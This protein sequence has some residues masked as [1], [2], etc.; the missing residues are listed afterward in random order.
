MV[1]LL[2]TLQWRPSLSA[3][4]VPNTGAEPNDGVD[5]PND[6]VDPKDGALPKEGRPPNP[7]EPVG[8]KISVK[9]EA[10]R[11]FGCHV[12]PLAHSHLSLKA[13]RE[14][15]GVFLFPFYNLSSHSTP[16]PPPRHIPTH[17][18]PPHLIPPH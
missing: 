4:E 5:E 11:N 2:L 16:P 8:R 6:E 18:T 14:S 3:N 17:P 10:S 9:S 12:V 13:L 1:V 15:Y 7:D